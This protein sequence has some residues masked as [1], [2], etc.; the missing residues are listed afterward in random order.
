MLSTFSR[1]VPSKV[2]EA[3]IFLIRHS[4]S[5]GQEIVLNRIGKEVNIFASNWW[6]MIAS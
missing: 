1:L 2:Y 5:A 3:W 6:A 4:V